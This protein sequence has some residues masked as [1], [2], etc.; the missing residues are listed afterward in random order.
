MSSLTLDDHLAASSQSWQDYRNEGSF[1]AFVE[2]TLSL[3]G[4]AEIGRAHV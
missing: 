2:F 1:E 3:N 4:L